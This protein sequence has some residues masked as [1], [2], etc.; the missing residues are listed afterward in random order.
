MSEDTVKDRLRKNLENQQK[1][2]K[3]RWL[4]KKGVKVKKRRKPQQSESSSLRGKHVRRSKSPINISDAETSQA[5]LE[6]THKATPE[7]T[8]EEPLEGSSIASTRHLA[9]HDK[10]QEGSSTTSAGHLA[11]HNA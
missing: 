9:I 7:S 1:T 4:K 2:K 5:T 10:P 8:Q 3:M 6:A 11:I